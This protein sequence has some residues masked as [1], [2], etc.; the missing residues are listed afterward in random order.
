M[1]H[2]NSGGVSNQAV[3]PDFIAPAGVPVERA[4][5]EGMDDQGAAQQPVDEPEREEPSKPERPAPAKKT[6]PPAKR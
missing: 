4:M 2:A 1:P 5:D 3:D 6:S